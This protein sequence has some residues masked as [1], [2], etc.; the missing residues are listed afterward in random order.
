MRKASL[1]AHFSN[2]DALF[3]QVLDLAFSEHMKSA[4]EAFEHS[5]S[6]DLPGEKYL[7]GLSARYASSVYFQFLLRTVYAPPRAFEETVIGKYR[8]FENE[9]RNFL[10]RSAPGQAGAEH[11]KV[12][13]YLAVVDSLQVELIYNSAESYE[14]RYQ[15][16]LQL[17]RHYQNV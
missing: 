9:L 7:A 2:K 6:E 13:A 11:A 4:Q 1:Y 3:D 16:V 5:Q 17:L 15:A 10:Q 12:E 14:I 8:D